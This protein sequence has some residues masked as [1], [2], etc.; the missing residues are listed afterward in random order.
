MA[1]SAAVPAAFVRREEGSRYGY[2]R[3][4]DGERLA[5]IG[6]LDPAAFAAASERIGSARGRTEHP[7][8]REGG[9]E[10][11]VKAYR[12]GG[13]LRG[14]LGDRY[15]GAGRF[16]REL[17]LHERAARI[18]VPAVEVLGLVIE[19]R[20]PF[21]RAWEYTRWIPDARDLWDVVKDAR[22]ED[23]TALVREAG[24]IARALA[25]AR[26]EHLDLS[27]RNILVAPDGMRVL[28]LDRARLLVGSLHVGLGPLAR[29]RRSLAKLAHL[30]RRPFDP[31]WDRALARGFGGSD[32]DIVGE[33]LLRLRRAARRQW[34]HAFSWRGR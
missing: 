29:L 12:R 32:R 15:F 9:L 4:R 8:I 14:L 26:I 23:A 19:R 24:S 27:A 1:G 33:A 31:E 34:I 30:E 17:E 10:V 11:V 2:F 25:E 22:P 5:E 13:M 7:V 6:A 3:R 20:G 16:E 21:V 18:G 28:D